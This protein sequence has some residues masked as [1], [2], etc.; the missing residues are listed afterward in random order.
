MPNRL[1]RAKLAVLAG[2][3][4]S[5]VLV[6]SSAEAEI[7]DWVPERY[8]RFFVCYVDERPIW[9]RAPNNLDVNVGKTGRSFALIAGVS[10]YPNM[11][12]REANLVPSR[13][14]IE[15]LTAYLSKEP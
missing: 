1:G 12:G 3:A 7:P 8:H 5:T 15:K 11:S 13:V 10:R 4:F 2:L 9:E 14:D 6:T